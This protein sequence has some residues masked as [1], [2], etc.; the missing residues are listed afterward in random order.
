[1]V[2]SPPLSRRYFDGS[3]EHDIPTIGLKEAFN[4]RFVVASQVNPHVNPFFF[5]AHANPN[6][7]GQPARQ[8]FLL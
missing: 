4:A 6:V 5:D 2:S 7:A 1:M 3:I 8:P